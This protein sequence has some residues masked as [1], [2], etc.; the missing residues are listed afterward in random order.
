MWDTTIKG[1][2][3]NRLKEKIDNN[4]IIINEDV[5]RSWKKLRDNIMEGATGALKT[6]NVRQ[7]KQKLRPHGYV[8]ISKNNVKRKRKRTCNTCHQKRQKHTKNI[9]E[10]VRTLNRY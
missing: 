4:P 5:N 9:R 7:Q 2:Y 1:L 10:F 3:Q 6:R 8:K